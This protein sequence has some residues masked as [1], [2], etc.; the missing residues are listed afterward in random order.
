MKLL[1]KV[2]L[3]PFD[4]T[5]LAQALA[6]RNQYKIFRWCRQREPISLRKHRA[7]FDSLASRE[8]VR[9][10]AIHN[11]KKEFIGVCGLTDIDHV[12]RRAEFS[13][14]IGPEFHGHGFGEAALRRLLDVAF[15]VH[16]LLV[17]WGESFDGN[18]ATEMFK[19]V[20]FQFEGSRR[21]FYYRDGKQINA[22]L[23]SILRNEFVPART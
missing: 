20:G 18:P 5:H 9:M 19:R 2:S 3:R 4:E 1:P 13:L 10:Y 8:D 17:V 21:A 7:W 15:S 16:N 6:W 23:W 22:S 14:Y 11:D 12:N